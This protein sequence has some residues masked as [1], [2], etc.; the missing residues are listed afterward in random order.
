MGRFSM[1]VIVAAPCPELM[2]A[3]NT[4]NGEFA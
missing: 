4:E 2:G 3:V 1:G